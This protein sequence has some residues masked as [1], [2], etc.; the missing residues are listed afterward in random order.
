MQ[1]VIIP[2]V[3]DKQTDHYLT[4][5][6][7]EVLMVPDPTEAAILATAPDVAGI[8]M[9]VAPFPNTLY[10]KLPNLKVL[11]RYGVGYDSIDA[12]YAATK[13]VW[14]TNTPGANSV[15]VAENAVTDIMLLAKQSFKV[16]TLM[17]SGQQRAARQIFGHE[18]AG[19][20][21]GIVGFGHIGQAVAKMLSS[22]G[23]KTLLYNR[24][25]RP[26]KYGEYVDLET[27]LRQSDFVTLHIAATKQT[28]HLI[29][30]KEL[31][32]M[33]SS[34][35]LINLARGSV[36]DEQALIKALSS[37]QI[38]N[39]A[40]DVFDEEPLPDDSPLFKLDNVFLT[41]HTGSNTVEAGENMAMGAARMIDEALSGQKPE[42]AVNQPQF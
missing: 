41:P 32:M 25:K 13:G 30:E 38:A 19:K 2:Q 39:A 8:M 20:T 28:E 33:K 24:T 15:S 10:D 23:V 12:D 40:L 9:F 35:S 18:L 14:V 5:K 31:K 22:F 6:G 4:K 42:W 29:G 34:A 7:Y 16:S 11:A 17:R 3:A 36:V 21:V 26:T 27:L 37:H 1:K